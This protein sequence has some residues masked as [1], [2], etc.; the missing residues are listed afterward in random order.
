MYYKN[1]VIIPTYNEKENIMVLIP[2]I[3]ELLPNI[4]IMVTDNDSPDGTAKVVI[5]FQKQYKNLFLLPRKPQNGLG[6]AYVN[7]FLKILKENVNIRKIIMMDADFAS[8]LQYLPEMIKKSEDYSVVIGSRYLS[9]SKIIGWN[10]WRKILSRFG[11][12]YCNTILHMPINDY[13][14]GYNVISIEFLRKIDFSKMDAS[15]YAFIIELK[16]LLYKA[17]ATFFEVPI[18]FVDRV[19]GKSKISF[20]II[21]EGIVAPW[22]MIFRK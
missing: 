16:Y 22:K 9:G 18:T 12:F 3:F 1:I 6:T 5:E 2:K 19:E 4:L 17:G 15:G 21:W 7:V 10:W 20:H 8:Q 14:C 11:N 13:T